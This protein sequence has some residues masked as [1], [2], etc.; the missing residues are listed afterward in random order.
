M[1][2]ACEI[3][4]VQAP[5]QMGALPIFDSVPSPRHG[6]LYN[7]LEL[8]TIKGGVEVCLRHAMLLVSLSGFSVNVSRDLPYPSGRDGNPS[9]AI[10]NSPRVTPT[11]LKLT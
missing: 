10:A 6:S 8:T 9:A 7:V 4:P 5:H 11:E 2:P 3:I 1:K